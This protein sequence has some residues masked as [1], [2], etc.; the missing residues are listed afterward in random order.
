MSA[1]F[2]CRE[3]VRL[4]NQSLDHPLTLI[5]RI[6][7]RTHLAMCQACRAYRRQSRALSR[8]IAGA[9]QAGTLVP[10]TVE[11]SPVARSRIAQALRQRPAA[12]APK[13]V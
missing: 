10:V 2:A 6:E 9:A 13:D 3:A 11:L 8:A 5:Q 1:M 4:A 7:L 12:G